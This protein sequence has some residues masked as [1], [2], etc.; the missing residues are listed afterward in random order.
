MWPICDMP[1]GRCDVRYRGQTG[2]HLPVL[3][4]TGFDPNRTLRG[5]VAISAKVR[6]GHA[7]Q[8]L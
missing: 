3:S 4:L 8:K 6:F 1:T 2:K 7:F 5:F